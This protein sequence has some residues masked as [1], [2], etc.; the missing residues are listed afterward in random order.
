[1]N[2]KRYILFLGIFF[3][4]SSILLSVL[5][6]SLNIKAEYDY[7]KAVKNSIIV[8]DE[9]IER[10][11]REENTNIIEV[12]PLESLNS[13]QKVKK[14][15]KYTNVLEI[16]KLKIKAYIYEGVTK[17]NLIYGVA[18]YTGTSNLG[19]KGNC[20]IAGHSSVTY[21]CIL[22]GIDKLPLMSKLFIWDEKGKKH[23]YYLA[24]KEV[25]KPSYT[26]V[27]N[28]NSRNKSYLTIITCTNK[29]RSRLVL[30][31]E[32][33]SKKDISQIEAEKATTIENDLLSVA[34]LDTEMFMLYDFLNRERD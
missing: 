20:A 32:E 7:D 14:V 11:D 21:N 23:K 19:E 27:L 1:M 2:F 25:V 18:H 29:G 4:L 8:T 13:D 24:S 17:E 10:K 30:H 28:T 34:T 5:Y 31:A 26:S 6:I 12:E 33:M 3:I 15:T 22:N 16:P 9:K